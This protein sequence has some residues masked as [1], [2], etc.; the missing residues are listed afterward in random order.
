MLPFLLRCSPETAY[1]SAESNSAALI[2]EPQSPVAAARQESPTLDL[3]V[4][5]VY[6]KTSVEVCEKRDPKG[7]YKKARAGIIKGFT[8]VDDPYEEPPNPEVRLKLV[9]RCSFS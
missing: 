5:Q 1:N 8:G 9:Q 4:H 7:L 2:S 6:L 3:S